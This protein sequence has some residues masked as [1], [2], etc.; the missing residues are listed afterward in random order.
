[1]PT[2]PLDLSTLSA[3]SPIDGRYGGKTAGLR[4]IVSEYGLIRHRVLVEV[5]WLQALA[6]QTGIAEIWEMIT[7]FRTHTAS[8]GYHEQR[9]R[10]QSRYWLYETISE[11][12]LNQVYH[13]PVIREELNRLE[14]EISRGRLTSFMAATRIL[15]KYRQG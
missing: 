7:E 15:E 11:G 5:R 3:V 1:M 10:E 9:R 14:D 6:D 8:S 12:I 2:T 13:D 4:P